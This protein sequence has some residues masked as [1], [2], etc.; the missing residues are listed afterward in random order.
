[1]T[2]VRYPPYCKDC[3]KRIS[4]STDVLCRDCRIR[5]SRELGKTTLKRKLRR[6]RKLTRR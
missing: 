1:M 2:K 4:Y 5:K 3:G 6:R